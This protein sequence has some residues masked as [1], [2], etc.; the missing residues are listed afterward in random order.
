MAARVAHRGPDASGHWVDAAAGIALAH[1]RLAIIDLSSDGAQPMVSA[2]GRWVLVFNGELYNFQE[3][4]TSLADA[5]PFRGRSDTEVL[6]AA[7]ATW[8]LDKTLSN[9]NGMFAF[10]LWDRVER[11]LYLARDRV[12]EK[13][14][15]YGVFNGTLVFGSQPDA[16]TAHPD[17]QAR[18]NRQA[19]TR[20]FRHSFV[21]G[22]ESIYDGMHR[23]PPGHGLT[24]DAAEGR[25]Q[26]LVP[27]AFWRFGGMHEEPRLDRSCSHELTDRFERL[28]ADA[29][30]LRMEADVPLGAFLSGGIDSS[31]TTALMQDQSPTPVRTF[32]V[33]M[34]H[35]SH[36][37]SDD[38]RRV[39]AHLGTDHTELELRAQDALARVPDLGRVYDEP[40]ADPSGLPTWL[41]CGLARDHVK[42]A[43]S[44]DGGDELFG[45]YN[46]YVYGTALW[47][48]LHHIPVRTR[49][50]ASRALASVK[51]AAWDRA[52]AVLQHVGVTVPRNPGDKAQKL[53]TMMPAATVP[54][55]YRALAST[56][57]QP[58]ALVVGGSDADGLRRN[59]DADGLGVA[60]YM[61]LRDAQVTLPDD[62]LV[63]VDRAS[64]AVG[65]EVRVPLLDHR[66]AEQAFALPL[67][68]KIDAGTGKRILRRILH[69]YVPA[70]LIDRP[71]MGFDPPL[72]DWLRGPLRPWAE[73]L[74]APDALRRDGL[75]REDVVRPVW[76]QH[77]SGRRNHDYR[78]WSVLMFQTWMAAR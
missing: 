9:S 74:L 25:A 48:R 17:V 35:A 27:R 42:V 47:G 16:L 46:R 76:E 10:A 4:R 56:W 62:M 52:G 21:A 58:D 63:K 2:D 28:L 24:V 41:I 19:L 37:E 72:A 8:G 29:V 32:T 26:A 40:F 30:R 23:L 13:P 51:P 20:Y 61:M 33:R 11:V 39:A 69:R 22:P 43:V 67:E 50:V 71:K 65:L 68:E 6:L 15:Y 3:V 14:L 34:D 55:L 57:Q 49:R 18:I 53:A 70:E 78:L 1:Q 36:D 77:L 64:M 44:G 31:L 66:V 5:Y 45:G 73:D 7:I 59:G 12:G 38:A 60:E 75:L 54:D